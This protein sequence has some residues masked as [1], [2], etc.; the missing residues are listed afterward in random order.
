VLEQELG[1]APEEETTALYQTLRVSETLRV[2][3][4]R[5]NLPTQST[6][7]IG[8]ETELAK[9][10]GLLQDPTCRLLTLVGP[11]GSGKTRLALEAAVARLN[12]NEHEHGV[13]FVP[14]ALLEAASAIVPT[15]A[16]VL[17]FRF[18]AGAT[19]KQQLLDY[20]R[21]KNL[22]LIMDNYEHLL[23]PPVSPPLGGTEG[24]AELVSDII[25]T[26][27]N[28]KILATSRA[29][30]NVGSEHRYH[31]GGMDFPESA[32]GDVA[33]ATKYGAVKLYLQGAR[34]AQT[35]F[36]LT[37]GNL[38]G[39]IEVCRLVAGMPL[40]IRLAAAWTGVLTPAEIAAEIRQGL[41]LLETER[42]D[43]PERQRS[44]RAAFDHSWNLLTERQ[45]EV[46]QALSVFGGPF[47]RHAAQQ[48]AGATL[49]E[50]RLLVDK[51]L[52]YPMEEG[53]Y[54]VHELLRQYAAERLDQT[55]GASEAAR[56]RHCAHYAAALESWAADLKGPR[57]HIAPAE[58]DPEIENVRAAWNWA[59][60]RK[61]AP[62]LGQAVEGLC[63]Y[64]DARRR[65]QDAEAA[66]R[67]AVG[68]LASEWFID[69]SKWR[70]PS[71]ASADDAEELRVLAR[72]LGWQNRY[73]WP[74][75]AQHAARD[76][77][78]RKQCL[79]L[80]D[81]LELAGL[82]VRLEKAMLLFR[83]GNTE[84][85]LA[86]FRALGD[87]WMTAS[88][89]N[90]CSLALSLMSGGDFELVR[91]LADESLA[92]YRAV[93]DQ[94]AAG[95]LLTESGWLSFIHDDYADAKQRWEKGLRMHRSLDDARGE[96]VA[97]HSLGCAAWISG[98]L[99][100]AEQL[101]EGA[102]AIQTP[103]GDQRGLA[104]SLHQLAN[105]LLYRGQ[106]EEA[107]RL[108]RE[109]AAISRAIGHRNTFAEGCRAL[110]MAR[111]ALGR[112]AEAGSTLEEGSAI[113]RELGWLTGQIF[114]TIWL[115]R[116][117]L[118]LGQYD[119]ARSFGQGCLDTAREAG[120]R[121]EI[122]LSLL[123]LGDV[124]LAAGAFGEAREL[125][126]ASLDKL[127]EIGYR[128][129]LS[130]ALASLGVATR[131]LGQ[132]SQAREHVREALRMAVEM[133]AGFPLL[134]ALP[135]AALL[136][137]DVGERESAV[138]LYALASRYPLVANSRW[139]EDVVGKHIAAAAE[140]LPPEVV[141]AAQERGRARDLWEAAH[142]LQEVLEHQNH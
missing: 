16:D 21:Q 37:D 9:I 71:G 56:D 27:P 69:D 5:H 3:P 42:R 94:R 116:A 114:Q 58:I 97:L 137:S 22:L 118:H 139:F 120:L 102:L 68:R 92:L 11:G 7:F 82:D 70:C 72:I 103:L 52:L 41:D 46:F 104:D 86:L 62:Y 23:A 14:L 30:L 108:A 135:V 28:V 2:S 12:A 141:A 54:E 129:E 99:G 121:E 43:V 87:D 39:F 107:E 61:H 142:E 47:S 10:A 127:Q 109:S 19:P 36:E 1:V 75:E 77:R 55:P 90:A 65:P 63:L 25:K 45:R 126:D 100:R 128:P 80:L 74:L 130:P 140:S 4:P 81:D 31:V 110:G 98:D 38:V 78:Q 8:R 17:G 33:D 133:E 88:Y 64:Y 101:L 35:D 138:E 49:R 79:A 83:E 15:V 122:A 67:L 48:V 59:V 125:L 112:Y 84:E 119:R 113:Y 29:R 91:Q 26:A 13:F 131:G 132:H 24:G 115:G 89:L 136:Q 57:S 51:S 66:C 20:L 76:R 105:V 40:A 85:S 134:R 34:R 32:P 6:P 111:F 117:H 18:Y 95:W 60:E 53:V 123:L 73:L 44:M 50:T 93:G 96:G 106:F 124:A